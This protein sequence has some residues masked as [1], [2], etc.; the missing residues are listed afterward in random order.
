[1]PLQ[2]SQILKKSTDTPI[3]L[4]ISQIQEGKKSLECIKKSTLIDSNASRC[5]EDEIKVREL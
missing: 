1:M 4:K 3:N 5:V 2:I